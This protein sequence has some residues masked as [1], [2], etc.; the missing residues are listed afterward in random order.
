MTLNVPCDPLDILKSCCWTSKQ[1]ADIWGLEIFGGINTGIV[2]PLDVLG[3]TKHEFP[4]HVSPS[5]TDGDYTLIKQN[6]AYF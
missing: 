2:R 1:D 5:K 6:K 4:G 3:P